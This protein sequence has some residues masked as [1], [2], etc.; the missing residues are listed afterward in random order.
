MPESAGV[1]VGELGDEIQPLREG[2]L[3]ER[4]RVVAGE[5]PGVISVDGAGHVADV[6][7]ER[8]VDDGAKVLLDRRQAVL[9][10]I[11]STDYAQDPPGEKSHF[12]ELSTTLLV[13]VT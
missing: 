10:V 5:H 2:D 13:G 3:L 11:F 4:E 6:A 9:H 12:A 8:G 1:D 7:G